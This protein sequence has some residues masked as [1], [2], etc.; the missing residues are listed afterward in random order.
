MKHWNQSALSPCWEELKI[1]LTLYKNTE[2][3]GQ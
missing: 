2:E 1:S 3:C